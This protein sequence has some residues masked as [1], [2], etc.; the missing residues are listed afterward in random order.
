EARGAKLDHAGAP[1]DRRRGLAVRAAGNGRLRLPRTRALR[2][3]NGRQSAGG[4]SVIR[5]DR[6]AKGSDY[7]ADARKPHEPAAPHGAPGGSWSPSGSGIGHDHGCAPHPAAHGNAHGPST[8]A[9]HTQHAEPG[10]A[11]PAATTAGETIYT[12]P[13]HPEIRRNAPGNCPICG[14]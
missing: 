12:C 2:G 9:A 13:M 5:K 6:T 14:M 11:P 4:V 1:S 3:G 8:R 10:T 7:M